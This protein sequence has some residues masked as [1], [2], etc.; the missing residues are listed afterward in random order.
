VDETIP[1]E[2]VLSLHQLETD[3]GFKS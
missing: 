3:F 1:H 2:E